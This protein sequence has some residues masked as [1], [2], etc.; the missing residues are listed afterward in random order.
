[1][2]QVL[3]GVFDSLADANL[4]IAALTEDGIAREDMEVHSG[5]RTGETLADGTDTALPVHHAT[6]G[7]ET[8]ISGLFRRIFG[9]DEQPAKVGHYQE[10]VRRGGVVL[11]VTVVD[12]AQEANV[13]TT[14]E[15]TGAINVD[16]HL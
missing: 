14:L 5:E 3:V 1:M 15:G 6:E 10:V 12:E 11:A 8:G 7:A 2:A 16:E 13:R 4:A 9:N